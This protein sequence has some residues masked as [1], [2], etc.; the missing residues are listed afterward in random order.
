MTGEVTCLRFLLW[1]T[2]RVA[3]LAK[4]EPRHKHLKFFR[5]RSSR[6]VDLGQ[7]EFESNHEIFQVSCVLFGHLDSLYIPEIIRLCIISLT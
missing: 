3:S 5:V 2:N 1:V 7:V 4:S 6:V